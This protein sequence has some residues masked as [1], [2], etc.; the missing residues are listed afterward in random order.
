MVAGPRNQ[1]KPRDPERSGASC[2]CPDAADPAYS[3]RSGTRTASG[4][5]RRRAWSGGS[6]VAGT[7]TRVA[8]YVRVSTREQS[9]E[10][11]ATERCPIG[12]IEYLVKKALDLVPGG[13]V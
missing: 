12:L 4:G 5:A 6:V 2:F 9:T 13:K 3:P 7:L 11:Q 8:I 1:R 10:T